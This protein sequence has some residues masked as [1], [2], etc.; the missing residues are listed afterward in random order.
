MVNFNGNDPIALLNSDG[1]VHDVV[2]SMGGADF[3]KDNTLARTTLTPSATYQ[4]SDWRPKAKTILMACA[5]DTTTPP[6]AFNCTLDGAEPSFTTIQQIQGEGSTSPYIQGYP[7]ITNED[8]FV[9]GVVSAV[10]TGLTK[11]FYLQSLEDDYNPNT[12]EGLFVFTNQ[13]SSDLAPGDV[14]CVKAKCR[15]ITT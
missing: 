4:A 12:S 8:F 6:S 9:K 14:V 15:S 10:T 3:A 11:G 5:L 2:G 7:Y 13:S 1:S